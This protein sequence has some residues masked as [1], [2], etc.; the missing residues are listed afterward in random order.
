MTTLSSLRDHAQCVDLTEGAK[1]RSIYSEFM[2]FGFIMREAIRSEKM[3]WF[4]Y[5]FKE[6]RL[7]SIV[8]RL[9]MSSPLVTMLRRGDVIL[10]EERGNVEVCTSNRVLYYKGTNLND[11]K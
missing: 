7:V 3:E 11:A 2:E 9:L 5:Y 8:I 6:G 4:Y 1:I 10:E